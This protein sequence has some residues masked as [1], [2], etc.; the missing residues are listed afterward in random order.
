MKFRFA[1]QSDAGPFTKWACENRDI[2]LKDID[3]ARKENNPTAMVLVI[4]TDEGVPILYVP[5][6]C[7]L[8]VSYLGFNPEAT[9]REKIQALNMMM[10]ALKG[11]AANFGINEIEVLTKSEYD[12]AK[13][14]VKH[15]FEADSRQ[16]FTAKVKE[17]QIV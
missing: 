3:S 6:Y 4:E 10:E 16:L 8:M 12:I 13:W 15:G 1:N 14:A 11:F 7:A 17:A 2:P 9:N 5:G